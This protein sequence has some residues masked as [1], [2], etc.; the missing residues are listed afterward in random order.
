MTGDGEEL[1]ERNGFRGGIAVDDASAREQDGTL[2][3]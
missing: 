1:R 3:L 2:R